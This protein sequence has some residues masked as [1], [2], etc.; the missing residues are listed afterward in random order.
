MFATGYVGKGGNM[1]YP[2]QVMLY[3]TGGVR[4]CQAKK[5]KTPPL[6]FIF[7]KIH[8]SNQR[9]LTK[10]LKKHT[11]GV[12]SCKNLL[13]HNRTS[14]TNNV[15]KRVDMAK[16]AAFL[17]RSNQCSRYTSLFAHLLPQITVLLAKM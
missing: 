4:I 9:G 14:L 7:S 5:V 8:H 15:Q 10:P 17:Q 2:R 12:Q 3:C 13:A 6:I 1:V 11:I 16:H